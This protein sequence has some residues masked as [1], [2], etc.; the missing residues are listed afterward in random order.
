MPTITWTPKLKPI[1][2]D[3]DDV[4]DFKFDFSPWLDGDEVASAATSAIAEGCTAEISA[5]STTTATL[6]VTGPGT[7]GTTGRATLRLG[8]VSGRQSDRSLDLV[9][10]EM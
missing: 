8:T 2:M 4:R 9:F 6:R 10:K 7:A 3:P 5:T 1:E